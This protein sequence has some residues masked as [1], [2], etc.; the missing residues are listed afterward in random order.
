M[1]TMPDAKTAKTALEE[2][3]KVLTRL[4]NA[5]DA[6]VEKRRDIADAD[7]EVQ[8]LNSDRSRLAQELDQCEARAKRLHDANREVS[9]R[10]VAAM[11]TIRAVMDR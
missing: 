11:E 6:H 4:E 8:R 9:R 5:V 10:L 7:E 2:L 3:T 1:A